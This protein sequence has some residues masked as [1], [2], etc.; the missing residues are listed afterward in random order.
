MCAD[1]EAVHFVKRLRG[2]SRAVLT[3]CSD[4]S[5]YAVKFTNNPNGMRSLFHEV[6]ISRL[7]R[8]LSLPVPEYSFVSV[9]QWLVEHTAGLNTGNAD[10]TAFYRQGVHFGSKTPYENDQVKVFE[11]LPTD[12]V[13]DITNANA[14][15]GMMA[16]DLWTGRSEKRLPLYLRREFRGK[17]E[18]SFIDHR[19]N[20]TEIVDGFDG[21]P[22]V[23][24]YA[25]W[26]WGHIES[27]DSFEP[28]LTQ[29]EQM[30]EGAIDDALEYFPIEWGVLPEWKNQTKHYLRTRSRLV[31]C[32]ISKIGPALFRNWPN[33]VPKAALSRPPCLTEAGA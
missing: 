4:G 15:A 23:G 5:Y 10:Q 26:Y 33:A 16:F 24:R 31:R 12:F 22:F 6:V 32:A 27:Y 17:F 21:L 1:V 9:S 2:S 25:W 20:L 29:M 13:T 8:Q 28:W 14:L 7:A 19:A 30:S 3:R 11:H 18:L